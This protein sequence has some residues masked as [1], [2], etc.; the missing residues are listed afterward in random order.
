MQNGSQ[1]LDFIQSSQ[2]TLV[3]FSFICFPFTCETIG[4][5]HVTHAWQVNTASHNQKE[6]NLTSDIVNTNII[7]LS[8]FYTMQIIPSINYELF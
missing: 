3:T 4:T 8:V 5:E 1:E 7:K 6:N 2:I